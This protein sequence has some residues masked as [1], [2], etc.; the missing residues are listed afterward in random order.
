MDS[1]K[2]NKMWYYQRDNRQNGPI[3]LVEVKRLITEGQINHET[4]VWQEGMTDWKPAGQTEL[5]G[6]L[7][8]VAS[9]PAAPPP[10]EEK[11]QQL[12]DIERLNNWF[13]IFWIC[14]VAGIPLSL[15][16]IG[17]AGLIASVA[18]YFTD[19]LAILINYVVIGLAGIIA[20]VVFYCLILHKCWSLI[21]TDLAKTTPS[22]AVGFL[23]IPF[24]NLYW[25]FV[26]YY[27][28]AQAINIET[29]RKKISDKKVNEGLCIAYCILICCTIIPYVGV[30]ASI[31]AIVI[32][33]ISLKQIKDAAI[34]LITVS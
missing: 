30:L 5:L 4:M 2:E 22:K 27:G 13:L 18:F 33:I 31:A 24:F 29:R 11:S 1:S 12:N 9:P 21:P 6:S 34:A 10:I 8:E 14:L 26:A 25:N 16:L 15:V 7:P 17:F 19:I 28:L 3:E 32:W 20:S 23:F